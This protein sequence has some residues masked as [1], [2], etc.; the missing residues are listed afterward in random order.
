[1][2]ES[3]KKIFARLVQRLGTDFDAIADTDRLK[4][5]DTEHMVE[6]YREILDSYV[7]ANT[8]K[9]NIAGKWVQIREVRYLKDRYEC[10]VLVRDATG[11]RTED[12]KISRDLGMLLKDYEFKLKQQLNVVNRL[13]RTLFSQGFLNTNLGTG[14]AQCLEEKRSPG[15][16]T[17]SIEACEEN[18]DN[19]RLPAKAEHSV[20]RMKVESIVIKKTEV[21]APGPSDYSAFLRLSRVQKE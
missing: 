4:G 3:R 17:E 12:L 15:K 9:S 6:L 11:I 21:A 19:S 7:D 5:V 18:I 1:M 16:S 14:G 20:K 2:S 13:Y 8:E 10:D